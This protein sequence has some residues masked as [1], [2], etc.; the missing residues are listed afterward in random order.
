MKKLLLLV[1]F[2]LGIS[3]ASWA[4]L[5]DDINTLFSLIETSV[6]DSNYLD[7]NNLLIPYKKNP[8]NMKLILTAVAVVGGVANTT[9]LH[10]AARNGNYAI[11]ALIFNKASFVPNYQAFSHQLANALDANGKKPI[12]Y[13]STP[14]IYNF[15]TYFTDQPY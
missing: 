15:L 12:F 10:V 8:T 1:T 4:T 9:P 3:H 11:T 5:Q 14:D 13:A 2:V 7:V 6:D